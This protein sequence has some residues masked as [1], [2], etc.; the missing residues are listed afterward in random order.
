MKGKFN[1]KLGLLCAILSAMLVAPA[2][3]Q[4]S[5]GKEDVADRFKQRKIQLIKQLKL[6]PDKEKAVLALEDKYVGE[7]KDLVPRL[8][9]DKDELKA[10]LA[11]PNPDPEK[12]KAVVS[13]LTGAM[14]ALFNSF[15]NQRDEELRLMTPVEQGKYLM[16]LMQ[17]REEMMGKHK[18]APEKKKSK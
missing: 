7:R 12:V 3:G 5:K 10:L 9:K 2:L 6:P 18:Q 13:D 16:A 15:K 14:D 17:W 1:F 8:K 11:S 4:V